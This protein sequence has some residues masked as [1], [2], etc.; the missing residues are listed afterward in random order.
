MNRKIAI[1]DAGSMLKT[2]LKYQTVRKSYTEE[3][4]SKLIEIRTITL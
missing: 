1:S 2:S 4:K 3:A